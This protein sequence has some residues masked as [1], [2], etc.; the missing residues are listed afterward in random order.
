MSRREPTNKTYKISRPPQRFP[1]DPGKKLQLFQEMKAWL[2]AKAS[3]S[4]AELIWLR[5]YPERLAILKTA[6]ELDL[7]Q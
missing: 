5:H 6:V 3:K 1:E 4:E 7:P 2:D